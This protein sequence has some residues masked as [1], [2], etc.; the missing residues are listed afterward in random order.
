MP[1]AGRIRQAGKGRIDVGGRQVNYCM[2]AKPQPCERRGH[3]MEVLDKKLPADEIA[4]ADA[5]A[6]TEAFGL[7]RPYLCRGRYEYAL[8]KASSSTYGQMLKVWGVGRRR[9][10]A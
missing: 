1:A 10:I 4:S 8:S 6:T 9:K 5:S 2:P 7:T 3:M